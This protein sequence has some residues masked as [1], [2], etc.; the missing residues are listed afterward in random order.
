MTKKTM[1]LNPGTPLS[2]AAKA[3]LDARRGTRMSWPVLGAVP[4]GRKHGLSL[5]VVETVK[6]GA[7]ECKAAAITYVRGAVDFPS[8]IQFR[9]PLYLR[10]RSP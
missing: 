1:V 9:V 5:T 2:S 3:G 6:L 10:E 4:Q 7:V 8:N